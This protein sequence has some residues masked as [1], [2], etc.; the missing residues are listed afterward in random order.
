MRSVSAFLRSLAAPTLLSTALALPLFTPSF[1]F[2]AFAGAASSSVFADEVPKSAATWVGFVAFDGTPQ[3]YFERLP[4]NF[5]PKR[6][7]TLLI[8]LHGHGSDGAQIFAG[9]YAEFEALLDVAKERGAIVV[10]PDYRDRTSWMGPAAEKDVAQIIAEQ[11]DKRDIT[12]VVISGASMGGSSALTFAVRRPDL[13]DGVI[14]IN[15]TANH[16]EY[17]NFQDAISA[18]FGGS[19]TAVPLEYKNR[20]A[21]YFPERLTE[22][23]SA[24]TLGGRDEIVPPNSAKRLAETL[25][26]IGAPVLLLYRPEGGHSTTYDDVRAAAEFVFDALE[27]AETPPNDAE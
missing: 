8:A 6:P 4:E 17:E 25:E 18:S 21:E 19:K 9:K 13:I 20:S 16:L 10:S 12:R 2:P 7:T 22:K 15:G 26:K 1:L 27:K 11:R 14:S 3:R 5:D 23:P 24:F